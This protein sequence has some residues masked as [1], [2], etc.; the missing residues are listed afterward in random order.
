MTL[1]AKLDRRGFTLLEIMVALSIAALIMAV[2]IPSFVKANRKEGLRKAVSDLVEGCA[3][4]RT[5]A[6]LRGTPMDLVIQAPERRISVAEPL[7]SEADEL[8]KTAEEVRTEAKPASAGR[9]TSFSREWP[10]KVAFTSIW[11]KFENLMNASEARIRFYPNGTGDEFMA[12]LSSV[13]GETKVSVDVVTGLADT[14]PL[15]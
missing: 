15:R 13:N 12:I 4:A 2:G 1:P 6:I 8:G 11:V 9:K 3:E 7:P 14:E 10:E 5:Q